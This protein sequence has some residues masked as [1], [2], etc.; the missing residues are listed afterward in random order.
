MKTMTER[1]LRTVFLWQFVHC[2]KSS[3]A[4][5]YRQKPALHTSLEQQFCY[6]TFSPCFSQLSPYISSSLPLSFHQRF[7]FIQNTPGS[8]VCRGC[9]V[10]LFNINGQGTAFY[11]RISNRGSDT[12]S[13][14]HRPYRGKAAFRTVH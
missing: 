3:S 4:V 12:A 14:L 10:Y 1:L 11:G 13:P 7:P 8:R 5:S 9:S 6:H 2:K